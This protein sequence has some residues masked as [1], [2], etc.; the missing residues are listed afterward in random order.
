LAPGT[1]PL[2]S[3]S[4]AVRFWAMRLA[5]YVKENGLP[6][7]FGMLG[8]MLGPVLNVLVKKMATM[9]NEDAAELIDA[10]H[11]MS[12]KLETQ[13]GKLSHYHY[14]SELPEVA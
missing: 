8:P 5:E 2:I 11:S 9:S 4:E 3:E 12:F 14:D 7:G 13:T 1:E 6:A 10:V